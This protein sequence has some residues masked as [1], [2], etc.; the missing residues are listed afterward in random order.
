[1]TVLSNSASR[2]RVASIGNKS[3]TTKRTYYRRCSLPWACWLE[4]GV[5]THQMTKAVPRSPRAKLAQRVRVR[6][7]DPLE[8][9]EVCVTE[10]LSKLGFYFETSMSHYFSG[11]SVGV[12]RNFT[13]GDP[14]NR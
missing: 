12:T 5:Y 14:V 1:M 9:E 11:M 2:W 8:P 7:S 13:P 10:N 6:P 4:G 3:A